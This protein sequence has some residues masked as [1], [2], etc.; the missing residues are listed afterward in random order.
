[1][2]MTTIDPISRVGL[3][4][5]TR[6]RW[7][8]VA[9]AAYV[10]S[11]VTGLFAAPGAPAATAVAGEVHAYYADNGLAIIFQ[12]SLIHGVAGIALAVMAM[13]LPSAT[14]ASPG[15]SRAVRVLGV[16][17]ALVSLLQV[18][19]AVF[20]VT[21]ASTATA[22]TTA[23][24]F[25]DLNL[26]DTVKLTLL[27][28][29]AATAT[30]AAVRAGMLARWVR[31]TA[32]LLVIALPVGGLAFIVDLAILTA[33]L[34]VSLPLLLLWAGALTWQVGRRAR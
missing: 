10:A 32:V 19:F 15:L 18:A 20:A 8:S 22:T 12:S 16:G 30:T 25:H 34:T 2:N 21:T 13:S 14:D 6:G 11:W 5:T 27:A 24:L 7:I 29:F 31:F 28:G 26:A 1:M 23:A 4:T 3:T 17:A 33:T 9:G